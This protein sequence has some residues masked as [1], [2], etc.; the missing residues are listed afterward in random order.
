MQIHTLDKA[1]LILDVQLGDHLRQAALEGR[2][3]DFSL[4]VAFLSWDPT[5]TTPLNPAFPQKPTD[6]DLRLELD[7]PNPTRL[8]AIP[9]D[10]ELG[11]QQASAFQKGGLSSEKLLEYVSPLALFFP[12]I[13]TH[14]L[15]E[16]VYHNLSGHVRRKLN[17]E[18]P[19]RPALNKANLYQELLAS[20]LF[21]TESKLCNQLI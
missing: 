19:P 14:D 3:A 18:N 11:A 9:E 5:E 8:N 2:R 13:G 7:V 6:A 17:D 21:L 15:G 16:E 12:A 20:K 4:M 1:R 10:Y